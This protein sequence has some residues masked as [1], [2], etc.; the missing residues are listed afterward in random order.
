MH[1]GGSMG[2][3]QSGYG[4]GSM[5][6]GG[7]SGGSMNQGGWGGRGMDEGGYSGQGSFGR[8]GGQGGMGG[9]GMHEGGSAGQSGYGGGSTYGM[10]GGQGG[11]GTSMGRGQAT[12]RGVGRG[13]KG[14]KRSDERIREDICDRL[15]QNDD[16]DS[17]DVEVQVS[18]GEVTLQGTVES[19]QMKHVIENIVD[20]VQGV[21]EVHN[22]L[23]V[24]RAGQGQ[25]TGE[26]K[27]GAQGQTSQTHGMQATSGKTTG[28][29][30]GQAGQ[31]GQETQ[32]TE[33]KTDKNQETKG[34]G[35]EA[36]RRNSAS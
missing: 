31:S 24:K 7:M 3:G 21:Q 32:K 5:S 33:G 1:E 26:D 10:S 29:I 9:R 17:S 23:R 6:R 18:G 36:T 16:L 28:Q 4:G 22:Q 19:R 34:Q 20:S 2:Q 35:A 8:S 25:E 15:M 30:Q 11:V 13:P 27:T 14:Y 12:Q